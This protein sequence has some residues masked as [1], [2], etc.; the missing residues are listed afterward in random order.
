MGAALYRSC[1][2]GDIRDLIRGNAIL[3]IQEGCFQPH[4]S[5]NGDHD[6]SKLL[7]SAE[8]KIDVPIVLAADSRRRVAGGNF[9]RAERR[10]PNSRVGF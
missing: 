5:L 8:N 2:L 1:S 4:L 10:T 3:G 6:P 9:S 7:F